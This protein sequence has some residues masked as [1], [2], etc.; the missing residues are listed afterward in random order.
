MFQKP[1]QDFI[2]IM[3][4]ELHRKCFEKHYG[5]QKGMNSCMSAD[6]TKDA[7]TLKKIKNNYYS[8]EN[9][10]SNSYADGIP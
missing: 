3:P 2:P 10:K 1:E 7:T 9:D 5:V 8:N 6:S 4:V